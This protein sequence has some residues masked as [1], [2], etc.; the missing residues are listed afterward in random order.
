MKNSIKNIIKAKWY[1]LRGKEYL[2]D[3]HG[4]YLFFKGIPIVRDD[5]EQ[6]GKMF[7]LNDNVTDFTRG[8]KK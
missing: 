2:V 5:L 8:I 1:D 7:F 6:E 4:H 3:Q